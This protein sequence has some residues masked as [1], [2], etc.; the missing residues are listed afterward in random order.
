MFTILPQLII[1]SF[2]LNLLWEVRHST[3]YKTCLDVP[4]KK[5]VPLIIKMSFKDSL[6]IG[7]FYLISFFVFKN[8]NI[9]DNFWQLTFFVIVSLTFSF[10]DEK[11]S[12]KKKRWEYSKKMPTILGVGITPFLEV[13]VTGVMAFI[14]I[15]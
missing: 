5:Y 7:L 14:I 8:V 12:L 4:L 1:I 9:L 2:F 10:F 11:I 3:L 13:A 6:F 15:P